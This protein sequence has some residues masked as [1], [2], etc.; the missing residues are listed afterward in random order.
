MESD[1]V[2]DEFLYMF[3]LVLKTCFGCLEFE[4]SMDFG[5]LNHQNAESYFGK[6]DNCLKLRFL[7]QLTNL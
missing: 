2:L 1:S 7:K 6:T 4:F 5:T 3:Y